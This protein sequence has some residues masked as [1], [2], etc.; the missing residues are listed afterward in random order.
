VAVRLPAVMCVVL[1][2]FGC[3]GG[4]ETAGVTRSAPAPPAPKPAPS[5][6]RDLLGKGEAEFLSGNYRAARD[7]FAR[8]W[9][10]DRSNFEAADG[11]VRSYEG[12]GEL[13]TLAQDLWS[14]AR[15]GEEYASLEYAQGLTQLLL[16]KFEAAQRHFNRAVDL[17]PGNPWVHYARAELFQ[18]VGSDD[19][20]RDDFRRV[21]RRDAK[22]GPALAALAM[23]ALRQDGDEE[24][25]VELL[26]QAVGHFRPMQRHQQVAAR[27]LLGRLYAGR[28]QTDEA[29]E[30][31]KS[32][33]DLDVAATY[34]LINIGSF[35]LE[36]GKNKAALEEWDATVDELGA[37]S[38]TGLDVLRARRR[39]AGDLLDLTHLLGANPAADYDALIAHIGTPRRLA[40][41]PVD[42]VLLP[43][44]PSFS[45][46]LLDG[47]EDLDGDG[48]LERLVLDAVQTDEPIPDRFLVSDA[49]LRIFTDDRD[50]PYIFPTG[51]DHF[52]TMVVQDLDGDGT[53][54][55]ILAG[56]RDTNSLKVMV[57]SRLPVGYGSMLM[58]SVLCSVPWAGCLVTDLDGDDSRELLFADGRDGWVDIYRWK[59][60]RP[61]L[62]NGEFPEFYVA[63]VKRWSSADPQQLARDPGI[64][65]K[66][67]KARAY[68]AEADR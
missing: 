53:K 65:V 56:V 33:R 26:E 4:A 7:F 11:L 23:L 22:H 51:F 10:A 31:F 39:R 21:L 40:A 27:V 35:L 3:A 15:I 34:S 44:I 37:D 17:A 14:R 57:I 48:R 20:A 19:A 49:V 2:L 46:V 55:V 38:P 18:A 1:L 54:E 8:A 16:G 61:V 58:V 41:R 62:A 68:L 67:R 9:S 36:L 50:Q 45:D 25:A 30:Q 13:R 43:Y 28:R 6:P 47:R 29:L 32:A 5:R 60:G 64:A 42:D 12:M 59:E 63:Y 24:K 66:L 52:H